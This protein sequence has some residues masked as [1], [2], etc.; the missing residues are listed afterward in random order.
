MSRSGTR[1]HL[2]PWSA[3]RGPGGVLFAH[4]DVEVVLI[5]ATQAKTPDDL[6]REVVES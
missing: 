5:Y 6:E 4:T 3:R 2:T 1:P